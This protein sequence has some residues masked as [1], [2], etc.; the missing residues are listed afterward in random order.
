L[1]LYKNFD[2][3]VLDQRKLNPPDNIFVIPAKKELILKLKL[4]ISNKENSIIF[5][6]IILII[7]EPKPININIMNA[8]F[9]LDNFETLL[10]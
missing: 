10:I 9:L 1:T 8:F 6:N 7:N 5:K 3:K 2:V 4:N